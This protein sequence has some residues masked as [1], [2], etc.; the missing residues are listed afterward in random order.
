MQ[1]QERLLQAW[2]CVRASESLLSCTPW[3]A[4][5]PAQEVL[6]DI[7]KALQAL[8]R[9]N[10]AAVEEASAALGYQLYDEEGHL[11]SDWC[12]R[13]QGLPP[14]Q[15]PHPQQPPPPQRQKCACMLQCFLR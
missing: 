10:R 5:A 1:W 11:A 9:L 3:H 4:R 6:E 7:K 14:R 12:R 15:Q 2:P 13:Q 8:A